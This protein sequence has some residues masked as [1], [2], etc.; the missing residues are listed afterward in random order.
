MSASTPKPSATAPKRAGRGRQRQ[1]LIEACI[2]ALHIHGPSRTTVEKVVAIAGMSPGI[3]R[4]YFD[5]KAAMLIASLQFLA[6]EFE[7]QLLLPVARLRDQPAV[8]LERLVEMYVGPELA[9]AR[10]VSVWYAFWGEANS[11]QEY[12]DICGKKDESFD[13]LV[14]ELMRRLIEQTG[15]AHL[16]ADAVALGLIGVLEMLWQGFAF[17][18][19]AS[20]DRALARRRGRAYLRSLFPGV[21]AL[22][23]PLDLELQGAEPAA[24]ARPGH[25]TEPAWPDPWQAI[26]WAHELAVPGAYLTAAL[27]SDRALV[28]CDQSR[29]LR[30]FRNRCGRQ[31]HVLIS[32]RAGRGDG[33][34]VC[35]VHGQR[36]GYDGRSAD[37]SGP[38]EPLAVTVEAGLV[39]VREA[40]GGAPWRPANFTAVDRDPVP[41]VSSERAVH[42]DWRVLVEQWI[43]C[44]LPE[45]ATGRLAGLAL[46]PKLAADEESAGL[47]WTA[48]VGDAGHLW[49]ARRYG[50]L[51]AQLNRAAWQRVLLPPNHLLDLR[52]DGATLWRVVPDGPGRSRLIRLEAKPAAAGAAD[53]ALS[54]LAE[55]LTRAWLEQ[56]IEVAES[57]QASGAGARAATGAVTRFRRRWAGA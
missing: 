30:A 28:V 46:S 4:F 22:E 55:R 13:R 44:A 57:V 43:E 35:A 31:P 33:Q 53:L 7:E 2:S 47:H 5:S 39:F 3:V 21:F 54:F 29:T 23:A 25:A 42:A 56:D 51:A 48:G 32:A 9:S 1:R 36:Y 24:R 26:G 18:T 16:D 37:G 27:A 8:A 19:E 40:P 38:L 49:S 6:A 41:I 34:L 10:K 11:R 15:S 52:P 20:I 12:Y 45:A 17:Q 50:R 14:R